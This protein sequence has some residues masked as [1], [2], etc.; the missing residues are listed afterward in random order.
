MTE[1]L[2]FHRVLPKKEIN[3]NDAYFIRGTL[4]SQERLENIIIK[5]LKEGFTFK[6]ICNLEKNI[7]LKQVVLTFD[8]GYLDNYIY[9]KPI[10]EKYNIKATF[11]PIIGYC[12]EQTIAPLDYYYH[13]VNENIEAINKENWITGK[14]KKE[15]INCPITEQ[16]AFIDRLFLNKPQTDVSYMSCTQLQE[17]QGLGHEIGGHSYYHDI[18]TKLTK[19][20]VLVDIQK[21]KKALS[22]I[23]INIKSYAY[24]DGQYNSDVIEVLKKEN[25][26]YSCAIKSNGLENDDNYELERQFVTENERSTKELFGISLTVLELNSFLKRIELLETETTFKFLK[27]FIF[28]ILSK[29]P[30]QNFKMIERG[31]DHLPTEEEIKEDMLSLNGGTCATM[32]VFAAAVLYKLGFDVSLINGTMMKENDHIAILLNFENNL[33]T[34]DLG[35]GQPYFEPIPVN[36]DIIIKHPFRTYR[37]VN[38]LGNLRIDFLINGDWS[39]DVTLDLKRKTFKEIYKTLEQHYT[40]L[41]FGPFWNGIRFAFYPNKKIIAI[42]DKVFIIQKSNSIEKIEITSEDHLT[43]LTSQYLPAYKVEIVKCFAKQNML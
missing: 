36:N 41:E 42:R 6:T 18:Y 17:L 37:T 10:L 23:G 26:D 31:F 3:I 2:M 27:E 29:I 7:D 40:E 33:Y 11:Y 4:V 38:Q 32:N 39:T 16:Q 22:Q 12:V 9:V 8:D 19:V 24:T 30:F 25:I 1:I 20:E 13:Y 5:Y 14:Q 28:K 35:D 15:F 34:I 43:E 21:A